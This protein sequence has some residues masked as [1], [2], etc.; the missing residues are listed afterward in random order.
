MTYCIG[1][2]LDDG[3]VM[4]ADTRSNAGIDRVSTF[5]KLFTFENTGERAIM[6]STSGNLATSQRVLSLLNQQVAR[7]EEPNLYSC[8]SMFQL[9]E[10]LGKTL[11]ETI[12]HYKGTNPSSTVNFNSDFILS[13]QIKG[14]EPQLYHVYPEG[15]FIASTRDTPFFQIGESKYGK[16]ILDRVI[17][18]ETSL[19]QAMKC[20]L[21]S[22]DSTMHSNLSVGMPLDLVIYK[23][24]S[25]TVK[26][27]RLQANDPYVLKLAKAWGEGLQ[28]L[29]EHLP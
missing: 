17:R 9:A 15:N 7:S 27:E 6:L 12:A 4:M 28:S 3:I 25:F 18:M 13:G 22:F 14:Q 16:P 23:K 19:N 11:S 5:P 21:I 24:E 20:A 2:R 1:M 8:E 10:L 26:L 29:F